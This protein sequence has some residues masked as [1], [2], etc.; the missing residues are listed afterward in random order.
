MQ[1]GAPIDAPTRAMRETQLVAEPLVLLRAHG[2]RGPYLP[3]I[4]AA[5]THPECPT[6]DPNR[7]RGLLRPDERER[8][9]LCRAKTAV[10]FFRMSRSIRNCRFSRRNRASS[11][12][13]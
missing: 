12:R 3:R 4:K 8:Y 11:L 10:A 9:S 6:Q 13:S 5:R 1:P 7:I 2:Q